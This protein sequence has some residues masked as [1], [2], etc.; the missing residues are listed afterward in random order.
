VSVSGVLSSSEPV[1]SGVM[2]GSNIG[3]I[4]FLLFGQ[5]LIESLS[6]VCECSAYADD[7]KFWSDDPQTIQS[8]LSKVEEWCGHWQLSLSID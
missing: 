1:K 7:I 3:P 6:H 5:S 8:A 2:Q 4:C